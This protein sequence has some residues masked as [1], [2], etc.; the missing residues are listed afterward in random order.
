MKLVPLLLLTLLLSI[1]CG[2]QT[3]NF[4][5]DALIKMKTNAV[6]YSEAEL[7]N[8]GSQYQVFNEQDLPSRLGED[9]VVYGEYY[10]FIK[11]SLIER[12]ETD[13]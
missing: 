2:K 13:D 7:Q 4:T 10:G 8:G 12:M 11:G 5:H 6:T 1:G 9:V 3:E